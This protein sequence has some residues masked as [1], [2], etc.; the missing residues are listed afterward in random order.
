M[1]EQRPD[2]GKRWRIL[3]QGELGRRQFC[4]CSEFAVGMGEV[5]GKESGGGH[6]LK[7]A[8][9]VFSLAACIE[10]NLGHFNCHLE[11]F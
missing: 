10:S 2:L 5:S 11:L 4:V 1:C 9:S 8:M 6:N 3:A 7:T